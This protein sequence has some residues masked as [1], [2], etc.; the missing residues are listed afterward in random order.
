MALLYIILFIAVLGWV[1]S[2]AI[3]RSRRKMLDAQDNFLRELKAFQ[4]RSLAADLQRRTVEDMER[5]EEA[6]ATIHQALS[7]DCVCMKN[8]EPLMSSLEGRE[9]IKEA[10]LY[11][12]PYDRAIC[13]EAFFGR[14]IE[15]LEPE[16]NVPTPRENTCAPR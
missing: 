14:G 10:L 6:Q 12:P 3:Q 4:D 11:M 5:Y 1:M 7:P 13:I 16:C 9:R 8:K 2:S 15:I